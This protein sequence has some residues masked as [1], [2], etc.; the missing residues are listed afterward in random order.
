[1]AAFF[2]GLIEAYSAVYLGG[3]KGALALF[4]LVLIVLVIKPTG[5]FGREARGA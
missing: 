1:V 5:L 2:V 3:S 4:V